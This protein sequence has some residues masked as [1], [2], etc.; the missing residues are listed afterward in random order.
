[1]RGSLAASLGITRAVRDQV[2]S[3]SFFSFSTTRPLRELDSHRLLPPR[4]EEPKTVIASRKKIDHFSLLFLISMDLL[5][6]WR[7]CS[8]FYYH[9]LSRT[10]SIMRGSLRSFELTE[11]TEEEWLKG[12]MERHCPGFIRPPIGRV[13]YAGKTSSYNSFR[14]SNSS[15]H[16]E[17]LGT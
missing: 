2:R 1:M 12:S 15:C 4:L 13:R 17:I 8:S 16:V 11:G 9:F 3:F 10:C 7:L 5:R 14:S 6:L